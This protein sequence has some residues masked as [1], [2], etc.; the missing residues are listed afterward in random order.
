M[1]RSEISPTFR[2]DNF[3]VEPQGGRS[4]KRLA[5]HVTWVLA[6]VAFK[7]LHAQAMERFYK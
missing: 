3:L 6:T 4:L 7:P 1:V 5:S 2:H